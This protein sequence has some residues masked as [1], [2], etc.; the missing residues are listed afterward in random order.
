MIGIKKTKVIFL[1]TTESFIRNYISSNALEKII[2]HFDCHFL[3]D[4][5]FKNHPQLK[6]LDKKSFFLHRNKNFYDLIFDFFMWRFRNKSKSFR[7]RVNRTRGFYIHFY[8]EQSGLI[9][10]VRLIFRFLRFLKYRMQY[11]LFAN[12]F[13]FPLTF[14]ILNAISKQ[15]EKLK[16]ELNQIN[17]ELVIYPSNAYE[18]IGIDI[19]NICRDL[20]IK[21]L[22]IIDNW[23]NVSSK[24]I[25]WAKPDRLLVWGEQTK[26]QAIKIQQFDP[27]KVTVIGASRFDQYFKLRES[28][29]IPSHFK[30]NYILFVGFSLPFNEAKLVQKI[31]ETITNHPEIFGKTKLIYRPHPHRQGKDTIKGMTLHNTIV[32]PQLEQWYFKLTKKHEKMNAPAL[33][34]YPALLMNAELV[35]AS[36]TSMIIES[37]IFKK[38]TLV[39]GYEEENNPSSPYRVLH[40]YHHF[41]ELFNT[42]GVD[43]CLDFNKFQ[44]NLIASW[45]KRN[46]INVENLE[47][48]CNYFCFNSEKDYPTR[49][50]EVCNQEIENK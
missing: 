39:I 28:N 29:N 19:V 20:K 33:D 24:S 38:R 36:L 31:D 11:N 6:S 40:D 25:L 50:Y 18:S 46:I 37:L 26:K 1:L 47:N 17:P 22:F 12:P 49:L 16:E 10:I 4:E 23:D 8:Q 2:N 45:S 43:I 15:D 48:D 14:R 13:T 34:Y 9:K 3:I 35:I 41:D 42:E 21:T 5:K 27:K 30:F 7:H 44:E 32:D